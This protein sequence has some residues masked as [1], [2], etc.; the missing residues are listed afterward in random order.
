MTVDLVRERRIRENLAELR[1]LLTENPKRVERVSAWLAEQ[2]AEEMKNDEAI[3]LRL[4]S[5]LLAQVDELVPKIGSA[6]DFKATRVSRSTVIRLA[7]FRGIAE[8]LMEFG[9]VDD[10]VPSKGKR[11]TGRVK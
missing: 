3:T 7:I 6:G 9:I 11:G 1:R 8:L 4:P 5:D 2:E 10:A